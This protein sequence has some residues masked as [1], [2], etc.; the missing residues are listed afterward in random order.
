MLS[1]D[2]VCAIDTGIP[3][4]KPSVTKRCSSYLKRSSSKVNVAPENTFGASTKSMPC[5]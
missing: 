5:S 2:S 4:S 1:G 3:S